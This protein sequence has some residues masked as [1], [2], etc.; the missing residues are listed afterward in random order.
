[1][2]NDVHACFESMEERAGTIEMAHLLR[3]GLFKTVQLVSR[4]GVM[5]SHGYTGGGLVDGD[6]EEAGGLETSSEE[7]KI[8]AGVL[9]FCWTGRVIDWNGV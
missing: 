4:V 7:W 1:M 3:S 5:I 8:R 6:G 9:S 2:L